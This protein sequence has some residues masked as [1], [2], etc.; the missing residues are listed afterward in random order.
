M[1]RNLMPN[2]ETRDALLEE[3]GEYTST[4]LV[5]RAKHCNDDELRQ[6]I[7]EAKAEQARYAA[8]GL[9]DMRQAGG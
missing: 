6:M 4:W 5:N 1:G 8:L 9:E 7:A 3:L 2:S